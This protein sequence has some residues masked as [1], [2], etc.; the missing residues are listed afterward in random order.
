MDSVLGREVVGI[1]PKNADKGDVNC[2]HVS[3]GGNVVATGDDFGLVK[4]FDFPCP[5][6]DV[7]IKLKL[8]GLS[9]AL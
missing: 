1:W 3:H 9:L 8:F 6:K 5:Q 4:L 2:A 7:S